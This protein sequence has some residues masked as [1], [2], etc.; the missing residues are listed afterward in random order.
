MILKVLTSTLS[1]GLNTITYLHSIDIIMLL[2]IILFL[3]MFIGK[4]IVYKA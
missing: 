1:I 4:N 3:S 2:Y